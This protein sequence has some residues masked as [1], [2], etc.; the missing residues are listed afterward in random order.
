MYKHLL[1]LTLFTHSVIPLRAQETYSFSGPSYDVFNLNPP[2]S[3]LRPPCPSTTAH[4]T[5]SFTTNL[6][7]ASLDN[8]NGFQVLGSDITAFSFTDNDGLSLNNLD[9][10]G[11]F[12]LTT[13]SQGQ[14]VTPGRVSNQ[15]GF[16]IGGG[17]GE[18][19]ANPISGSFS[20]TATTYGQTNFEPTNP[21]MWTGPAAP[22]P[23]PE[24][25]SLLL[26]GSAA[27]VI[28]AMKIRRDMKNG[29]CRSQVP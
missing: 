26:F 20:Q 5:G 2:C 22:V 11:S 15:W 19:G 25:S 21:G 7:L 3:E 17:L 18:F 14:I 13:N 4:I 24:P 10:T 28:L 9:G 1:I 12:F 16:V 23:T 29:Y 27:M 6:S 8:L